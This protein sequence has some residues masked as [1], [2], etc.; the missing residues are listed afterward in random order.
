[1]MEIA[2]VNIYKFLAYIKAIAIMQIANGAVD[3]EVF[4]R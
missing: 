4:L 3:I 2:M 1:M